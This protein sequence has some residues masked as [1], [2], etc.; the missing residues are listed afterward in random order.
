MLVQRPVVAE[1]DVVERREVV[2]LR[3]SE[4]SVGLSLSD[5]LV[6]P[7]MSVNRTLTFRRFGS[8]AVPLL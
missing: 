6:N 5:R 7:R 1:D 4:I 3:R 8:R 2:V